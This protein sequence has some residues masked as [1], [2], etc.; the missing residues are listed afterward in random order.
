MDETIFELVRHTGIIL[1]NRYNKYVKVPFKQMELLCSEVFCLLHQIKSNL[2]K[3]EDF[4]QESRIYMQPKLTRLIEK[5]KGKYYTKNDFRKDFAIS[6]IEYLKVIDKILA[7]PHEPNSKLECN[8]FLTLLN[9]RDYFV[10]YKIGELSFFEKIIYLLDYYQK[11]VDKR[12]RDVCR[13]ETIL[14][15][16]IIK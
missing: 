4:L 16:K 8:S 13:C 7:L 11:E 2:I 6:S 10:V 9:N 15:D 3:C 1:T 12:W 14:N 5:F